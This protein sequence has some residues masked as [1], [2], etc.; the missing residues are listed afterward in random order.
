M[1]DRKLWTHGDVAHCPNAVGVNAFPVFPICGRMHQWGQTFTLFIVANS[2][3]AYTQV[4]DEVPQ[5]AVRSLSFHLSPHYT[6]FL[7]LLLELHATSSFPRKH[8]LKSFCPLNVLF[9]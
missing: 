5:T 2:K 1:Y 3:E 9:V 8:A 6:F 4:K 7:L